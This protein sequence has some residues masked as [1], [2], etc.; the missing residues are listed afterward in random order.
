LAGGGIFTAEA[1]YSIILTA[2]R[3]IGD[4]SFEHCNDHDGQEPF[5]DGSSRLVSCLRLTAV[6][7]FSRWR[8]AKTSFIIMKVQN[9]GATE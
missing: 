8:P 3:I 2:L 6:A 9:I 5:V 7:A 1:D 4:S